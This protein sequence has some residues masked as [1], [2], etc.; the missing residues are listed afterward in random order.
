MT[1]ILP[2]AAADASGEPD[3]DRKRDS[4]FLLARMQLAGQGP[5]H[6][7]R[8]RNLSEGGLMAE[9]PRTVAVGT[10][11]ALD[12]RGIGEIA[13]RVAWCESQRLGIAFDQP[14]DPKLARK[15]VGGGRAK[16]PM[17]AKVPSR[18]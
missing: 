7:V 10:P 2:L 17:Q 13:G 4:L 8:V 5:V 16:P 18:R 3:G 6:E 9:Y 15:P 14:V 1:P 12:M 11:V